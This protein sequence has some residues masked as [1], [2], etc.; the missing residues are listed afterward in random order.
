MKI[1]NETKIG[2]MAIVGVVLLVF[3]FNFLKGK[4][5]FKKESYIYAVYQ[6]VQLLAKS[7]PV[8]INGIRTGISLCKERGIPVAQL[9]LKLRD[10]NCNDCRRAALGKDDGLGK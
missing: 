3:G 1:N 7:N 9:K 8:L 10:I 4:S 6:D 2:V 5:L